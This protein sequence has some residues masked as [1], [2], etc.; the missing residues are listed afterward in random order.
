MQCGLPRCIYYHSATAFIVFHLAVSPTVVIVIGSQQ[1]LLQ[2]V[3]LSQIYVSYMQ[4]PS[5]ILSAILTASS[6]EQ[7][8]SPMK[9]FKEFMRCRHQKP[10]RKQVNPGES[11]YISRQVIEECLLTACRHSSEA[12]SSLSVRRRGQL[13]IDRAISQLMSGAAL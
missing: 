13:I 4:V 9:Y 10:L 7:Q 5:P 3:Q 11:S 2:S 8:F 6:S 1:L 12:L